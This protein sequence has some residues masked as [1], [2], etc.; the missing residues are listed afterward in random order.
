MKTSTKVSAAITATV[1]KLKGLENRVF[2]ISREQELSRLAAEIDKRWNEI[3]DSS[4]QAA[5][6][7]QSIS[8]GSGER[9]Q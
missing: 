1:L 8:E 2:V 7:R 4:A 5:R 6:L 9:S 3:G